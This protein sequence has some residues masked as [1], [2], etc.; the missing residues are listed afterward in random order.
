MHRHLEFYPFFY[1]LRLLLQWQSQWQA[2][3]DFSLLNIARCKSRI[4]DAGSVAD[5]DNL[6]I[7]INFKQKSQHY[8][9]RL[10]DCDH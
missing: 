7:S 2:S 4:G 6:I 8:Q 9:P 1:N 5:G 3:N 10:T